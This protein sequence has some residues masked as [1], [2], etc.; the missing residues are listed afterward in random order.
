MIFTRR[1][2]NLLSFVINT[3]TMFYNRKAIQKRIILERYKDEDVDPT[4]YT[5][6]YGDDV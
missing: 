2:N 6:S 1:C 5:G 4:W 3:I